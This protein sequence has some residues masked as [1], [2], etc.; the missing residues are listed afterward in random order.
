M[1]VL[2]ENKFF[3]GGHA[4]DQFGGAFRLSHRGHGLMA[5]TESTFNVRRRRGRSSRRRRG[6]RRVERALSAQ[7]A[8]QPLPAPVEAERFE[9]S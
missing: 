7:V 9:E 3:G 4:F 1:G 2:R 6:G 5:V 8:Q